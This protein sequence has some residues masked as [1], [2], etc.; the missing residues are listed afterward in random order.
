MAPRRMPRAQRSLALFVTSLEG[1]RVAVRLSAFNL[2]ICCTYWL[3]CHV[4]ACMRCPCMP[5]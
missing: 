2:Y 5:H 1:L 3:L 4:P